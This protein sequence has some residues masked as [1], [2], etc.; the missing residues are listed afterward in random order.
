VNALLTK[1]PK[2]DVRDNMGWTALAY[3][4]NFNF[5][6]IVSILIK[7]GANVNISDNYDTTPFIKGKNL[8]NKIKFIIY[9]SF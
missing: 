4:S 1:N 8:L 5:S 2:L 9:F 7:A 3:A 6:N